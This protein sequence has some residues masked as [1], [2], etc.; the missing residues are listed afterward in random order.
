VLLDVWGLFE[1]FP[2]FTSSECLDGSVFSL[3]AHVCGELGFPLGAVFE[4]GELGFP[5]GAV[6]DTGEFGF[7]V[8][9]VFVSVTDDFPLDA[10]TVLGT[11]LESV[12]PDFMTGFVLPVLECPLP[13]YLAV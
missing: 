8:D 7:P 6:F 2:L 13:P 11:V 5:L 4:I 3:A 12:A 1:S 9:A 10:V